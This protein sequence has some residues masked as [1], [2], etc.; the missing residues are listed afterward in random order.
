MHFMELS[1][2]F[3]LQGI[4]G[5]SLSPYVFHRSIKLI[6]MKQTRL[7]LPILFT[8]LCRNTYI[9]AFSNK[10]A[11]PIAKYFFRESHKI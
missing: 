4:I 1:L 11:Q 6:L 3:N 8:K 10:I 7:K 2:K 9:I 5:V